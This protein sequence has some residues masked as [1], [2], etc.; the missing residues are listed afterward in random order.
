MKKRG[1]RQPIARRPDG[2][3]IPPH[4]ARQCPECGKPAEMVTVTLYCDYCGCKINYL[5]GLNLRR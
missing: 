4:R 5:D 2:T 1:K 3:K